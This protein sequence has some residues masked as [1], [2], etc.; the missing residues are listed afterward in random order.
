MPTS[1]SFF[2]DTDVTRS[3]EF[4]EVTVLPSRGY[5]MLAKAKRY[6]RWWLLKGLQEACRNQTIYKALLRKEYDILN[7]LQHPMVVSAFSFETVEGMGDCI[8][9]EWIEGI[10]LKQWLQAPHKL[11]ERRH[12]AD[13]L[14]EALTYIHSQQTEHCDLKPSN[15]MVTNDGHHL[16]LIDFGLSDTQNYAILKEEAGT[17]GYMAPDGPSDIYSLGIILCEL[18]TGF[19]SQIVIRRCLAPR[20][21]R[22]EN[23]DAVRKALHHCWQWPRRVA[24]ILLAVILASTLYYEGLLYSERHLQPEIS[25]IR[26]TLTDSLNR[27]QASHQEKTDSLQQR[28]IELESQKQA[29]EAQVRRREEFIFTIRKDIDQQVKDRKIEQILD[30]ARSRY[31]SESWPSNTVTQLQTYV[32]KQVRLHS[33]EFSEADQTIIKTNLMDYIENKYTKR[34][35]KRISQLPFFRP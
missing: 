35:E 23:V 9:M 21:Q 2:T 17:E 33:H 16:K 8:V 20:A 19:F 26:T 25:H 11:S 12:I 7:Q 29:T 1:E 18:R 24:A 28:I 5:C 13:L 10:T 15:V 32:D 31:Y 22:I 3:V 4:C 30:T 6:G 34:W 27:I 14:T